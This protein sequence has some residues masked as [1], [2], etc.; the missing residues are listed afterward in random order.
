[1][2]KATDYNKMTPREH[3]LARSDTYIGSIEKT[4]EYMDICK[5]IDTDK[6][7]IVNQLITFVPGFWKCFDELLVNASDARSNDDTCDTI[8]VTYNKEEKYIKIYNNG[9]KGI[10]VE[11]HP[12]YKTLVPSMIFGEML[13]SSNYDDTK[14]RT[15]GGRNG[16]GA[17]L[18][19]ILSTRFEVTIG[20]S[21]NE[22]LYHQVW[23]DNMSIIEKPSIKKY[24]KKN[25]FVEVTFYPDLKRFGL[26]TMDDDHFSLFYRRTI[27]I[28]G[29][30]SDKN[31]IYF[32][33]TKINISNFKQYIQL[34]YPDNEIYYDDSNENWKVG[35][36][37]LPESNSKI[38]SFV[39]GISTYNGGS[40]VT[41]VTDKIIKPL[42]E[43]H[44][45]KKNKDIKITPAIIKDNLVFFIN[46]LIENPAFS[47]QTK[48][49]LTTKSNKF[50]SLY[51]PADIFLKKIAKSGIVEQMIQL[52]KFK[53]TSQLKKNDGK[54]VISLHGIPKLEDAN[55]AGGKESNK[56][57]LFLTEGDSAKAL[58][59]A[60]LSLVG[61]DYFGV[62]PLKGK[63]LNFR[64]A[65]IKQQL[66]N[67]EIK[68][69]I[70]IIGL[71]IDKKYDTKEDLA[72]LRYHKIICLTDQDVD[73]SHIKGLIM[74]FIHYQWPNLIKYK[75][76]IT[77]LSTPI[78]KAFKN[79]DVKIF[80]NLTEY[81]DWNKT[82]PVGWRI[83][84][85]KGLGTSTSDEA[86]DY[87]ENIEEKLI[88]FYWEKQ[89]EG[90]KGCD[91][92]ITLAF[93]KNRADDRKEWLRTYNK[94]EILTCKDKKVAFSKFINDELKHFSVDDNVRSIPNIIDG[95]KP[96][97]RKVLF[98]A[99]LRKL[100][101]DEVKVAQLAGFV[102]DKAAYHHGEMSLVGTII[103]MA[104]NFVGSNNINLLEPNGQFGTRLLGGK[105][106]AA[107]RY[108][109][110]KLSPDCLKIF[111]K[112]DINVLNKQYEDN[113]L[114]E[115]EYYAP[116]IP[117][118]LVNGSQGI[119]TGFSTDIPSFNPVDIIHNLHSMMDGNKF[120]EMKPYF[121]GFTGTI[122]KIDRKNFETTGTFSIK[123]NIL[124]ITE[125]PIGTWTQTYKDFLEKMYETDLNK[126]KED[127]NF[128]GFK[129]FHTDKKVHFELEFAPDYLDTLDNIVKI[130]H[131][132]SKISLNNMHL[133]ST[134]CTIKK[135]DSPQ[136]IM[137]EYY[138]CRLELYEKRKQYQLEQMKNELDI[139]SNK[140]RFILMVIDNTLTINN[141]KKNDIE[142]DLI[143]NNFL[144]LNTNI[145]STPNYEYLL[146]M[147][148]YQLTFEKLEKLKEELDLTQAEYNALEKL[149]PTDIWKK[150]LNEL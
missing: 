50:G 41:H 1:M 93:Q 113:E 17:K 62:F 38:V 118:I 134:D 87:F 94:N 11:E 107:S 123:K 67:E 117:M 131:L 142:I 52:A 37:Y 35:C 20:D 86:K 138:K 84:Y 96:S 99:Y 61:R 39:N 3:V 77:S 150:E 59:M 29:I 31:K 68:N 5:S 69:L 127:R 36:L 9:D 65:S 26:D 126:P 10:P 54:K 98:G 58:A 71:Q 105:D 147:S 110:T 92:A 66:E 128:I 139:I 146:G 133:F 119:G 122:K 56:C 91:D 16:Y 80:Y 34:Y 7:T 72:T 27:D 18:A 108:I 78:I 60:G 47:S 97:Q 125:L 135:Y 14:K 2:S 49:T 30:T 89:E 22:K 76:F 101:R 130:F 116:I 88:R 33:D 12:E 23:K 57:A 15:T 102:S 95:M 137:I 109:W 143:S 45:K 141:R 136:E 85:Y 13:T 90:I 63:L 74:N 100:E 48:D 46:S 115:P 44:I 8:K 112:N 83:K 120:K 106:S 132:S 4:T 148:I 81:D 25:S 114:I 70:K 42:I 6:Y 28:A 144:K 104:Q 55:K 79:K 124:S 111:N 129:E 140:V 40:H 32:N 103:G 121:R 21:K 51:E 43:D 82:N 73:G 24:S 75:D 19:N 64:E 149:S 53:E 145:D